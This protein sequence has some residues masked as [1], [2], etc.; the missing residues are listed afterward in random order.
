MLPKF[1][2]ILV[3]HGLETRFHVN[4]SIQKQVYSACCKAACKEFKIL[5]A[6]FVRKYIK[7]TFCFGDPV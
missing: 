2:S 7:E 6:F 3:T 1:E 5:I 4:K